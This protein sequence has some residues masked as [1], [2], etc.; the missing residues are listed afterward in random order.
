M[1]LF[2]KTYTIV[3]YGQ[4]GMKVNIITDIK[5][6]DN[7]IWYYTILLLLCLSNILHYIHIVYLLLIV[8]N[9]CVNMYVYLSR[10]L[11]NNLIVLLDSLS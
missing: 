8:Y 3:H 6:S 1:S 11:L 9:T 5:N 2:F 4:L 7:N 10:H